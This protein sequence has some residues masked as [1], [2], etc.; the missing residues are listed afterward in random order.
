[1]AAANEEETGMQEAPSYRKVV[2]LNIQRARKTGTDLTQEE[3]GKQLGEKLGL[4]K[5]ILKATVSAIEVGARDVNQ[6]ELVALALILGRSVPDL[7]IPHQ[8]NE[9]QLGNNKKPV[10]V[11]DIR[12][13]VSPVS[14]ETM[15]RVSQMYARFEEAG[16]LK[17]ASSV[18]LEPDGTMDI[19]EA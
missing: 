12:M 10:A 14:T 7:L 2:G 8:E 6:D 18:T 1:M 11:G 16:L 13:V 9:V 17:K 5:P 4:G 15:E 3:L 19:E